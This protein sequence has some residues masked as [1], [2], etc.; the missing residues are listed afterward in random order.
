MAREYGI[1]TIDLYNNFPNSKTEISGGVSFYD[2]NML[3]DTH[4]S[5]V[6]NDL[7]AEII[8]RSLLGNGNSGS[9]DVIPPMPQTNGTY[10]LKVVVLNG[11]HTLSWVLDS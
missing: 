8:T 11:V 5:A 6:G 1:P 7:V 2:T 9:V 10:T 4:F 3:N